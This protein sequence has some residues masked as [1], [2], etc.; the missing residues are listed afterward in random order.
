[1]QCLSYPGSGFY[2]EPIF[3]LHN[4]LCFEI[5]DFGTAVCN[6]IPAPNLIRIFCKALVVFFKHCYLTWSQIFYFCILVL[7]HSFPSRDW[8][9]IICYC[10]IDYKNV[11]L[12][13]ISTYYNN[14]Q[15]S[16]NY[17]K[18]KSIWLFITQWLWKWWQTN[19]DILRII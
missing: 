19:K 9:N 11:K 13:A 7:I 2:I 14:K 8:W 4:F 3:P 18:C 17:K 15:L 10:Y 6:L 12:H 16:I 5:Y 1:M